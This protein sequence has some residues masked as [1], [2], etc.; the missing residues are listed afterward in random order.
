MC[1]TVPASNRADALVV[2]VVEDE[3]LLRFD[4][5]STLRDA[6]YVVV[7]T[8]SGEEAIAFCSSGMPIDIVFTD[9]N[10]AGSATGWDVGEYFKTNCPDVP[11]LYTSGMSIDRRRCAPGSEFVPKPYDCSDVLNACQRLQSK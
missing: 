7:E 8:A 3:S 5:T 6:G 2:L 11:V 4:I 10:L 9:I 1:G